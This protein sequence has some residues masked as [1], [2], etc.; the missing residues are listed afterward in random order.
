[1]AEETKTKKVELPDI[2]LAMDVVDTLRHQQS[3]VDRELNTEAYDQAL[4][5]KVRKIY[6]AQGLEVSDEIIDR[7]V[8][9]LR[10]NRFAYTAPKWNF[11][12]ALARIYINRGRWAKVGGIVVALLLAVWLVY[13]FAVV[14]PVERETKRQTQQLDEVWQQFQATKK[15]ESL[16]RAGDRLYQQA[17]RDLEAGKSDGVASVISQLSSLAQIPD[18]L[19]TLRSGILKESRE[20]AATAKTDRLYQDAMA[21]LDRGDVPSA[22]NAT[23]SLQALHR[24]LKAEYI[25]QVVSQPDTPSGVWRYPQNNSK[26]RNYYII[27]QAVTSD[28]KRMA[29]PVTNEEDSK[30][31]TVEMWGIRVSESVFNQIRQDKMDNGIIDKNRFGIKR[32][33]L[34]TPEY[35]YPVAGGAITKW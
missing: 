32:R 23:R 35:Q 21:A 27:V 5:K 26:A 11:K 8:A 2:M 20:K 17:K 33:G 4:I 16:T 29:L 15:S 30:T 10:E 13:Q 28:G 31:Q 7:G 14:G 18:Q 22:Q 25:L 24:Q 6:A 19:T 1:M 12:V 9:A 3:M 34:L